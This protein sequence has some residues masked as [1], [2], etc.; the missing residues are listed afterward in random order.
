MSS[1]FVFPAVNDDVYLDDCKEAI[2]IYKDAKQVLA[3]FLKSKERLI[4]LSAAVTF[5]ELGWDWPLETT[6]SELR[7]LI[8]ND[9]SELL[10]GRRDHRRA[11]VYMPSLCKRDDL[12]TSLISD[13]NLKILVRRCDIGRIARDEEGTSTD[14]FHSAQ[15]LSML[16]KRTSTFLNPVSSYPDS[17]CTS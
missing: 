15:A 8:T 17:I 2:S 12:K 13:E 5:C 9:V 16:M 3:T 1:E 4:R 10:K 14:A 11:C 6:Y 7:Q